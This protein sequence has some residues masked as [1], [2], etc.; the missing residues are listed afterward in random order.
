[1][2]RRKKELLDIPP[3]SG[4]GRQLLVK[5]AVWMIVW[6]VIA[7]LIFIILV[8]TGG[9]IEEALQNSIT[10]SNTTINPLLPIILIIIAFIATFIGNLIISW[11]YNLIYTTK[12]YD[13]RKMFSLWLLINVLL[14]LFFLPLYIIFAGSVNQLFLILAC[15]IIVTVFLVYTSMEITTNPNYS[16]S[17]LVGTSRWLTVAMFFFAIAYK[18]IGI[19]DGSKINFLLALPPILAYLFIPLCHTLREKVYYKFYTMWNNFLYIP[20]LTEVMIDAEENADISV[21]M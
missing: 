17:H 14:F 7:F 15:H 1:M 18:V 4:R 5:S 6:V 8:F 21:N 12:Y 13:M 19:S 20:S 11:V 10:A 16:A 2:A 3:H 9:M